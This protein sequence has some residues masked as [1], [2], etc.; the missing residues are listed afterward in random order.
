MTMHGGA[1]PLRLFGYLSVLAV[2]LLLVA[3]SAIPTTAD[4]VEGHFIFAQLGGYSECLSGVA[5]LARSKVMW[6]NDK[7]L[8]DSAN[9]LIGKHVYITQHEAPD[10]RDHSL[11]RTGKYF[12]F[13]DPNGVPWNVT[14]YSYSVH[15]ST[16]TSTS[17]SD[18]STRAGATATVSQFYVYVVQI[19]RIYVD[20]NNPWTGAGDVNSHLHYNFVGIVDTCRFVYD[21]KGRAANTGSTTHD[22]TVD[23]GWGH[24]VMNETETTQPDHAHQTHKVDIYI[25]DTPRE[26]QVGRGTHVPGQSVWIDQSSK[27]GH[28]GERPALP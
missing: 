2:S 26:I 4:V 7:I 9:L 5:G 11:L 24:D 15:R 18:T 12:D 17:G 14:E 28:S 13:V 21:D 1:D 8:L 19:K 27:V 20:E 16:G 6:F 23:N 10:P 25:G 22:N 3:P